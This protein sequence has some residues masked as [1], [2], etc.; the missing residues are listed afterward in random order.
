MNQGIAFARTIRALDA[1]DFRRSKFTLL[2]ATILLVAWTWWMLSARVAQYETTTNV[3]IGSDRAI[4]YFPS[5][6]QI[7]PGQR[8]TVT[9]GSDAIPARV[10]NVTADHAELVF[11]DNQQPRTNNQQPTTARVEISRT[12]PAAIALRTLGRAHQ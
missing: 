6:D 8:A 3:R 2:I 10:Q 9:F 4:A 5:T 7:R 11:S 12:S 1:D